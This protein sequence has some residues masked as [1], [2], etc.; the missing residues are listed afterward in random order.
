M[1]ETIDKKIVKSEKPKT[2]TISY[3]TTEKKL[4]IKPREHILPI[5]SFQTA[6]QNNKT[7]KTPPTQS[8]TTSKKPSSKENPKPLPNQAPQSNTNQPPE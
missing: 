4:K 6:T 5:Y 2:K 3:K 7:P 8:K 1:A